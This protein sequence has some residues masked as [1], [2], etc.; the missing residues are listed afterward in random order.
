MGRHNKLM[1]CKTVKIIIFP[2]R[3]YRFNWTAT[4]TP[5]KIFVDKNISKIY[6]ES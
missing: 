4:K 5:T 3:I 2:K 6:M 1:D